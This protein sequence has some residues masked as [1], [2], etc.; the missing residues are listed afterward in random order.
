[1]T[2]MVPLTPVTTGSSW[3]VICYNVSEHY[4]IRSHIL[5]V[6]YKTGWQVCFHRFIYLMSML[7]K[8][9]KTKS[10]FTLFLWMPLMGLLL[11]L[12]EVFSS[13]RLINSFSLGAEAFFHLKE[14]SLAMWNSNLLTSPTN[15]NSFKNKLQILDGDS[16]LDNAQPPHQL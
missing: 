10:F 3:K 14:I 8:K 11:N 12:G 6:P 5:K 4:S 13:Q 9:I 1:M 7:V 2:V 16:E 15:S